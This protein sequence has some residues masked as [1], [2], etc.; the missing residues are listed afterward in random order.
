MSGAAGKV[1]LGLEDKREGSEKGIWAAG[2]RR[3][4]SYVSLIPYPEGTGSP[5]R[6]SGR[7]GSD[8]LHC[9][10]YSPCDCSQGIYRVWGVGGWTGAATGS[11]RG[12]QIMALGQ[13]QPT[14]RLHVCAVREL[15][16]FLDF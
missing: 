3:R 11:I 4:E 10:C 14:E 5:S 9:V 12:H 16:T 7:E 8:K 6:A 13:T 1:A 15:R 2:A